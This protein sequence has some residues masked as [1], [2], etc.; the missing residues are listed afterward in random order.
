VPLL[1][2]FPKKKCHG[3]RLILTDVTRDRVQVAQKVAAALSLLSDSAPSLYR[4]IMGRTRFF[5]VWGGSWAFS[6]EI[7]GIHLPFGFVEVMPAEELASVLIHEY[8][9]A[10]ISAFAIRPSSLG[11]RVE[12]LC[13]RQQTEFLR[14]QGDIWYDLAD[15]WE[16]NLRTEWWTD[17]SHNEKLEEMA[18]AGAM[19]MWIARLLRRRPRN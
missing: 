15:A 16:A 17:R 1:L 8:T 14:S 3:R 4:R 18:T 11:E 12:A 9:H 2:L 7:G 5:V 13:V 6:D 19:P 10:R